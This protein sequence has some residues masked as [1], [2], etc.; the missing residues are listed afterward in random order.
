MDNKR[1]SKEPPVIPIGTD[2][3]VHWDMLPYQ[4]L[5]VRAYMKSTYDRSGFNKGANGGFYLY[6][7]SDTFNA[8]MDE[9]GSGTAR[10]A[11]T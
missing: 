3:Y 7:E 1:Y 10:Q 8:V 2:A 9:R 4:K 5:N 11:A 6:Q